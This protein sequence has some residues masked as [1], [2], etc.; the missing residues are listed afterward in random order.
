MQAEQRRTAAS[1]AQSSARLQQHEAGPSIRCTPSQRKQWEPLVVEEM[2]LHAELYARLIIDR[3]DDELLALLEDFY[4]ASPI[5]PPPAPRGNY[6]SFAIERLWEPRSN[7]HPLLRVAASE[8]RTRR[9]RDH[10]QKQKVGRD[11]IIFASPTA[12]EDFHRTTL[13]WH[14]K[15][16]PPA[17][18]YPPPRV[19]LV[20]NQELYDL[21][22]GFLENQKLADPRRHGGERD[23]TFLVDEDQLDIVIPEDLNVVLIDKR[24]NEVVASVVRNFSRSPA[25][26]S[27]VQGV[28]REAAETRRSVRLEDPGKLVQIGFTSGSRAGGEFGLAR[29]LLRKTGDTS[30]VNQRNA[31]AAAYMWRHVQLLHHPSIAADIDAFHQE[32]NLPRLDGSWPSSNETHGPIDL[33]TSCAPL[34]IKEATFAPGCFVFAEMYSRGVHR[35]RPPHKYAV[36]WTTLREGLNPQGSHFYISDYAVCIR[37]AQDTSIAWQPTHFH[38]TCLGSWGPRPSFDRKGAVSPLMNQ[39]VIAIVTSPRIATVYRKFRDAQ[40]LTGPQRF[41]GAKAELEKYAKGDDDA[42]EILYEY[43]EV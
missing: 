13:Y 18:A 39:Q 41:E 36:G 3:V 6:I 4:L 12:Y 37:Q 25:M 23:P 33:P 14:I 2:N 17:A 24:T 7:I 29:N 28:V 35:E 5:L 1:L 8:R 21:W 30:E 11:W 40:G 38:S 26:L 19:W 9:N 10:A 32:H 20:E 15:K 27:W 43:D 34:T 22:A 16:R 31:V 42:S